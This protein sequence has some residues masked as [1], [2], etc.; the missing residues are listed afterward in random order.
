MQHLESTP[1]RNLGQLEAATS[2]EG[3]QVLC[4]FRAFQ[5]STETSGEARGCKRMREALQRAVACPRCHQRIVLEKMYCER[6]DISFKSVDGIPALLEPDHPMLDSVSETLEKR[7]NRSLR[8]ILWS[9]KPEDRVWSRASLR[10]IDSA[11]EEADADNPDQL[12]VNLGAGIEKAFRTRLANKRGVARVG[13]PHTG[14]VDLF[15][16]VTAFPLI[17][18][19]VDL[20]LSS[21]VMEHVK[22][23][24]LGI[25]EMARVIKPGGLV[26]AEI[27]FMRSFH[28]A[29]EDYQ[30][31]TISGIEALFSR[32]GFKGIE[33]GVCSGPFNAIALFLSDMA[34]AFL[35]GRVGSFFVPIVY[36]IVHPI[37]FLDRLI[38]NR[39]AATFQAC[40]FYYLGRLAGE[41]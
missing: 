4:Y 23:P 2:P 26:Y 18:D 24:E 30:R 20:F 8:T 40:N 27:P 37:K 22:D 32:H 11:L 6:C 13:L 17:D 14:N 1:L 5:L 7:R 3:S 15:G 16:D 28:M 38:E 39:E 10:A 41:S 29:P 19:S 9:T 33:K 35:D 25:A 21:S 34:Q 31:Y 36:R 12:V